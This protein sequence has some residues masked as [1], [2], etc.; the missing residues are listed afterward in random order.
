MTSLKKKLL[1]GLIVIIFI[2][3]LWLIIY[4]FLNFKSTSH[5]NTFIKTDYKN[6][7]VVLIVVDTLRQDHLTPYDYFRN[8]TPI[9]DKLSKR[10]L[11]F[12]NNYSASNWTI[13][14]TISMFTG[15]YPQHHLVDNKYF[16]DS[17]EIKVSLDRTAPHL[18]T[19]AQYFKESGYQTAGFTGGAGVSSDAGFDKGFDLYKDDQDFVGFETTAPQ[20]IDWL[21]EVAELEDDRHFLFLHGYDVHGQ[22]VN[23]DNVEFH[24]SNSYNG[25]LEGTVD[26]HIKIRDQY[27]TKGQIFLNA[28]DRQF[29]IDRYDDKIL[30]MDER[31]REFLLNYHK[32][33]KFKNPTIF[34]I[35]ADHGEE[36]FEHGGID[37]GMTLYQEVV[38]TPLIINLPDQ[39]KQIKIENKTSGIDLLPTILELVKIPLNEN[40]EIDGNSFVSSM[41][42]VGSSNEV[43]F[44]SNYR[45]ITSLRGGVNQSNEKFFVNLKEDKQELYD[46]D[47]DE[48]EKHNLALKNT[49]KKNKMLDWLSQFFWEIKL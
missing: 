43:L 8:T 3:V 30:A 29:L 9:L 49:S 5:L 42:G 15:V 11:V 38:K 20:A 23:G 39:I 35:T 40:I 46:L 21:K 19:I 16:Y 1:T 28:E 10:S 31:L 48:K 4:S 27:Q 34:I 33:V 32:I 22:Y 41:K 45:H 44:H 14:S 26:E 7:N 12:L 36:W 18:L 47:K 17:P 24:F 13:P 37:H 2:P 25:S 6:C